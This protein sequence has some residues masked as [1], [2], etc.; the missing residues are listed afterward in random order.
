MKFVHIADTHFD[1][2]FKTLDSIGNMR[3]VEQRNVFKKMID[4][5]KANDIDYLFIAG[6]LFEITTIREST[7]EYINRLFKE[8]PNTKIFITPGNHDP[9]LKNSYYNIYNWAEN[10][11]IFGSKIEKIVEPEFNLYG[12]GFEDFTAMDTGIADIILDEKYKVNILLTHASLDGGEDHRGVYNAITSKKL[13][14]IGFDYCALGHIHKRDSKTNIVYPG[15]TCAIGF[16]EPGEHGMIVGEITKTSCTTKFVALDTMEFIKL[17]LDI[18]KI[19]NIE[20]LAQNINLIKFD[21]NKYYELVFTGYHNFDVNLR[22]IKELISSD[23]VLKLKDTTIQNIDIKSIIK[24]NSLK[25]IFVRNM[26]EE[27]KKAQTDEDKEL[28]NKALEYGLESLL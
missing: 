9:K 11:Y 26:T 20:E 5:I 1:T 3:R 25:G 21:E 14:S 27:I 4:Y 18:S 10:V 17:D 12:Y 15:S 2:P 13:K 7:I 28:L 16:D 23:K 19:G 24:E 22:K 8:I 6:D